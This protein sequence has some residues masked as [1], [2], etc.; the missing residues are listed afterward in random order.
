MVCLVMIWISWLVLLGVKLFQHIL[1]PMTYF[2]PMDS[3]LLK[4]TGEYAFNLNFDF[5]QLDNSLLK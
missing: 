4:V 2:M 5:W 3:S 1:E